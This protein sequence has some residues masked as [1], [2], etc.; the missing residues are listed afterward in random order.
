[1][2]SNS[3]SG[4]GVGAAYGG[5]FGGLFKAMHGLAG[6]A[7]AVPA[8]AAPAPPDPFSRIEV[9]FATNRAKTAQTATRVIFGGARGVSLLFGRAIVTVPYQHREGTVEAPA[10]YDFRGL[11]KSRHFTVEREELLTSGQWEEAIRT[12]TARSGSH[13]MLL[14]VH[15]YK[16]SFE[17]A[18]FRTAQIAY[19]VHFKGAIAMFSWP[20][21][22][23]VSGYAIDRNNAEYSIDDFAAALKRMM[24]ATNST[25]VY[26]IAHSMGN[27]IVTQG[28]VKL[29]HDDPSIHGRVREL[30]LAAP[31]IDAGI[32]RQDIAPFLAQAAQRTT[33]YASSK[34]YAL[35]ASRKLQGYA[36]VG[37]TAHGILV[38]PPI[39]TVDA[40]KASNDFLGHSYVA[41]SKGILDDIAEIIGQHL[42]PKSRGLVQQH[43][44]TGD[45]WVYTGH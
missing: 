19:D 14:F 25:D 40:S 4:N 3:V 28:L 1:V 2:V 24:A 11:D 7:A 15:G 41:D 33:L 6:A 31:D 45:Y 27:E 26:I 30:I 12:A 18:L 38:F 9:D 20:S 36:R 22:N 13:A 23:R 8:A 43:A 37:D 5:N 16:N 35:Y 32:F 10:W 44:P 42:P 34:D 17:D 39:Q 21:V 29:V